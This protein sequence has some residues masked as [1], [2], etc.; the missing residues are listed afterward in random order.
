MYLIAASLP[1]LQGGPKEQAR[2][3]SSTASEKS[4]FAEQLSKL[5]CLLAFCE[6]I[7][8]GQKYDW[9]GVLHE[10]PVHKCLSLAAFAF[11]L[12]LEAHP[13]MLPTSS[14]ATYTLVCLLS[15]SCYILSSHM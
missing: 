7:M 10:A 11:C 5:L 13:G 12:Y 2:K 15:L 8:D 9:S 1:A 6:A 14:T 3:L 4:C